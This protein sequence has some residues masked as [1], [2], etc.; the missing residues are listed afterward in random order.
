M[1]TDLSPMKSPLIVRVLRQLR[2]HL[3]YAN[4]TASVAIFIALAGNHADRIFQVI[5]PGR[6]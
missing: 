6:D 1:K 2:R 4:A 5:V 3:T